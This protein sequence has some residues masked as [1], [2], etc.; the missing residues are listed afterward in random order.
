MRTATVLLRRLHV[1]LRT[2]KKDFL[3]YIKRKKF[4]HL[5]E[6]KLIDV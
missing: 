6:K 3:F 5:G 1:T 4:G 2:D